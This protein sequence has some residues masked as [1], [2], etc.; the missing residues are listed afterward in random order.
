LVYK[1]DV[2]YRDFAFFQ[3]PLIPYL[4]GL[5]QLLLGPGVLVGRLTSLAFSA[6]SVGVG[7]HLTRRVGGATAV[8]GLLF[9]TMLNPSLMAAYTSARAEA[10]SIAFV[11]L[12]LLLLLAPPRSTFLRLTGAPLA[13]A[14]AT[15]CRLS[16]LPAFVLTAAYTLATTPASTSRRLQAAALLAAPVAATLLLAW[17][18]GFDRFW[19]DVWTTQVTRGTQF[20]PEAQSLGDALTRT[21]FLVDL[22]LSTHLLVLVPSLFLGGWLI[23]RW[24]EGWRPRWPEAHASPEGRL[25][26]ILALAIVVFVPFLSLRTFEPRYLAP[27]AAVL[28]VGVAVALS[29]GAGAEPA[30]RLLT[31]SFAILLLVALPLIANRYPAYV[32]TRHPDLQGVSQLAG[33]LRDTVPDEI[34][35]AHV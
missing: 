28:A 1:G 6:V 13:L 8:A 12:A 15:L 24:L 20:A 33:Q 10:P 26:I 29:R 2:P 11:M 4:Y 34:G 22:S 25:A 18:A 30:R 5:P 27:T 7:L 32:D 3:M 35:R 14:L 31:G 21:L 23:A 16:F 9:I 19:F 17:L